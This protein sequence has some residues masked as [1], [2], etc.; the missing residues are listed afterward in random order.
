MSLCFDSTRAVA[1]KNH[2]CYFCGQLIFAKQLHE[3][4]SG[5]SDGELW[6]LHAHIE[7]DEATKDWRD[8]DYECFSPGTMP[9]PDSTDKENLNLTL[10]EHRNAAP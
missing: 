4:R 9:R 3:S 5:V 2:R 7:C 8:D 10:H 1:R 6:R